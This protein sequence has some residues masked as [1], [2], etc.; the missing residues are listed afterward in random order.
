MLDETYQ[1][2]MVTGPVKN[3]YEGG[4]LLSE[5]YYRR[6][7]QHGLYT[8]YYPN[9]KIRSTEYR[10]FSATRQCG[11]I[12]TG[13]YDASMSCCLSSANLARLRVSPPERG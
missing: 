4:K 10:K 6:N 9:G 13:G 2:G 11:S 7:R 3:Y 5:S 8:S 12:R 1:F